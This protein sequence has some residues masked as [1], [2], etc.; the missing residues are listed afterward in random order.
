[1]FLLII[2]VGC[3]KVKENN[4]WC[5]YVTKQDSYIHITM[6]NEEK[7]INTPILDVDEVGKEVNCGW[8]SN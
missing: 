5:I 7:K 3:W 4:I 2:A 8:V 6:W 1:M